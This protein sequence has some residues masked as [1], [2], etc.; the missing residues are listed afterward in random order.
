MSAL[1]RQANPNK[2]VTQ[3][4]LSPCAGVWNTVNRSYK[5]EGMATL[6]DAFL[7]GKEA[8]VDLS[9]LQTRLF[10]VVICVCA[11]LAACQ[12]NERDLADLQTSSCKSLQK[13]VHTTKCRICSTVCIGQGA[14][15]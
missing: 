7:E 14:T 15:Q 6:P 12:V 1:R 2:H 4:T 11:S 9:A 13:Q 3:P 10:V 5:A 8:L